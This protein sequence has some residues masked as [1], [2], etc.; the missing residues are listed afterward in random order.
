MIYK[1]KVYYL[2]V[3]RQRYE[4]RRTWKVK[5]GLDGEIRYPVIYKE[6]I[7][8]EKKTYHKAKYGHYQISLT[9]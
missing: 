8:P 5:I 2:R 1:I 4:M 9:L 6:F 3:D 7:N